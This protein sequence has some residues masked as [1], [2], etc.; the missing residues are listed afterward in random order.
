[1]AT[2]VAGSGAAAALRSARCAA[3]SQEQSDEAVEAPQVALPHAR[4]GRPAAARVVVGTA[5]AAVAELWMP[6]REAR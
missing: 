5:S 1:V 6:V 2:V 3:R 4:A